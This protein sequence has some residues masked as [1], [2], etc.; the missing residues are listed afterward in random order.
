M[1]VGRKVNFGRGLV[2]EFGYIQW[3]ACYSSV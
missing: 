3:V 2:G 1:R